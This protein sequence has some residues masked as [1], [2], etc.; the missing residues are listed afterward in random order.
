MKSS[1]ST[2]LL[3][4]LALVIV[5]VGAWHQLSDG[6]YEDQ[7]VYAPENRQLTVERMHIVERWFGQ[8]GRNV[9]ELRTL[10]FLNSI[11]ANDQTLII[12]YALGQYSRLE[13]RELQQWVL[14]GGHL[15][16]A[17][18]YSLGEQ[19]QS[20]ELNSFGITT[21]RECLIETL[22]NSEAEGEADASAD[23]D[24]E[25]WVN[26][27][28]RRIAVL[29][30]DQQALKLWSENALEVDRSSNKLKQWYSPDGA[31]MAAR[32]A[33]GEGEI[34]LLP[35]N[36]WMEN[37]R[38]IEADHARLALALTEHRSGT[39]FIQHFSVPGGLLTWLWQLAPLLWLA[40]LAF[41]ALWIWS[42]LPRLGAVLADPDQQINQMRERLR[43]TARFDWRH[44]QGRQ[45]MEALR[46]EIAARAQ[47]RYPD[48]HRLSLSGRVQ[49]LSQLCP[50]LSQQAIQAVLDH[51]PIEPADRLIDHLSVQQ[52]LIHAL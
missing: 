3:I 47:R 31:A 35:N 13:A 23:A 4:G 10:Q 52:Q 7:R 2:R 25:P 38:M 41:A 9:E 26:P 22:E 21:C 29:G 34:T 49:H 19:N 45:L 1:L 20:F 18:P 46:E 5:A 42:R 36:G 8:Q 50:N 48:W 30:L 27:A 40:L 15:I 24:D 6:E 32:Y 33:F 17:A 14:R 28:N 37:Q 51:P 16:A 43:A 11:P 12:P 44:N 39:I